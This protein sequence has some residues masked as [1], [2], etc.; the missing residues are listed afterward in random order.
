M[1]V[2]PFDSIRNDDGTFKSF[3]SCVKKRRKDL[4]INIRQMATEI[5]MTPAYLS[6]IEKGNRYAPSGNTSKVDFLTKMSHVLSLD[7]KQ[8]KNF[9]MLAYLSQSSC[10]KNLREYFSLHQ[11]ALFVFLTAIDENWSNDDW[12]KLLAKK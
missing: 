8:T 1:Y 9:F 6:D 12:K 2:N 10:P 3:G 11:E 5:G 7:Q 4:E